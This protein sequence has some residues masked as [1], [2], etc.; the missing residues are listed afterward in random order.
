MNAQRPEDARLALVERFFQGTGRSYDFMV[1]AMTFGID[2]LWKRRL[3][4][5][6]PPHPTRILDLACGT[7][8]ST[9]A[10]AKRHPECQLVGVELRDE[11]LEIARAKLKR[12]DSRNIEL[13]LGRAEDYR[14][15]NPFDCITSSY[16]AKY[17]DLP[18]LCRNAHAM[19]KPNGVFLAHDFTYPPKAYLVKIW[20][21]YFKTLQLAGSRLFPSWRE[22]YYGLPELIEQSS[23]VDDLQSALDQ[24]G[25]VDIRRE[26]L[27]LYGSAI[28]IARKSQGAEAALEQGSS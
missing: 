6:L 22:I 3:V 23:W 25:F 14:S 26:D 19:L 10:I 20:N 24:S 2:R 7:G 11:Y 4:E 13:V 15:E 9:L 1:N 18:L 5:L 27:T 17:A 8:I 16:L 21:V 12:H 28:V